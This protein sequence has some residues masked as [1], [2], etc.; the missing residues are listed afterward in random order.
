MHELA[1][2][3]LEAKPDGGGE[4]LLAIILLVTPSVF[5]FLACLVAK[6][7]YPGSGLWFFYEVSRMVGYL[8]VALGACLGA[9]ALHRRLV[10]PVMAIAM[11][12]IVTA[13]AMMSW[14]AGRLSKLIW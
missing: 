12:S 7:S 10:T 9:I 6:N 2:R 14:Y 13:A 5:G 4:L 3:D 1:K 11:L 8:G